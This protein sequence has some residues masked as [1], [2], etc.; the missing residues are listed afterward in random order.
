MKGALYVNT[1]TLIVLHCNVNKGRAFYKYTFM[2]V[3]IHTITI[4]TATVVTFLVTLL[5]IP[6]KSVR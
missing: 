2:F 6:A 3:T 4:R 1:L 5:R